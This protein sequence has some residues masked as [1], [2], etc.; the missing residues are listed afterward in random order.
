LKSVK[1]VKISS[2]KI[3][4]HAD[5]L[6]AY[7]HARSIRT[8]SQGTTKLLEKPNNFD[9]VFIKESQQL[10]PLF[11]VKNDNK[12]LLFFAGWRWY[13]LCLAAGIDLVEVIEY[14]TT[15]GLDLAKSAWQYLYSE[16]LFDMS[17]HDSLG[18]FASLITA[19]P[20]NY[21]QKLLA[22]MHSYSPLKSVVNITGESR[23]AV[24]YQVERSVFDS[25]ADT[26]T[27]LQKLYDS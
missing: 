21:R 8:Y 13:E 5:A 18:Q 6:S 1:S 10:N 11:A 19:M 25:Q 26:K 4:C 20:I 16:H 24:R 2:S 7:K 17:R 12:E 22:S 27:I 9:D 3:S 14:S 15:D 23:E